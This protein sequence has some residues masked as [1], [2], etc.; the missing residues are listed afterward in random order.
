MKI[1]EAIE[2]HMIKELLTL[3][4]QELELTELPPI[5]LIDN[6]SSIRDSSFG[7]F[8]ENGIKVVTKDRHPLDVVR[9]LAH[10]LTHWKQSIEGLELDGSDGSETENQANALAGIIMR[11]F[12][13][14]YP[15][16]F[17][18]SIPK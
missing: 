8:D 5:Q 2:N 10:E 7:E 6:E 17:T 13:K 16:Y 15:E 11:K 18:Q 12:A 4:K 1:K 14:M 3:C 9:T